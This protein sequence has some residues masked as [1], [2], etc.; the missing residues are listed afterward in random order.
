MLKMDAGW[1]RSCSFL[2]PQMSDVGITLDS[3]RP[4]QIK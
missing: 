4:G 1:L 2:L 3:R